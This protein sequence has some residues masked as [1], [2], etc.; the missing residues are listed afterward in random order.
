MLGKGRRETTWLSYLNEVQQC[1]L[2]LELGEWAAGDGGGLR[3]LQRQEEA[4]GGGSWFLAS[5]GQEPTVPLL[6]R[7]T[8]GLCEH[9]GG[10]EQRRSH[11]SRD[12][13]R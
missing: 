5:Q 11:C 3:G 1:F 4:G 7:G 13:R 10:H 12:A 8:G 6:W 2:K 9:H